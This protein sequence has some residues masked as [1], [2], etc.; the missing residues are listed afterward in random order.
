M[1]DL[2]MGLKILKTYFHFFAKLTMH[3]VIITINII[4]SNRNR[5]ERST[6]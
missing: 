5:T 6:I 3:I 2:Q 4:K 1:H